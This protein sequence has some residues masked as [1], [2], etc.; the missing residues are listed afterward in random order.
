MNFNYVDINKYISV[1]NSRSHQYFN[2]KNRL[3]Y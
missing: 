3:H 1:N 2:K